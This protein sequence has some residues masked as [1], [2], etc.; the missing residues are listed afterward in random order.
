MAAYHVP[1]LGLGV[2]LAQGVW[3]I[4]ALWTQ[5]KKEQQDCGLVVGLTRQDQD[6]ITEQRIK[7]VMLSHKTAGVFVVTLGHRW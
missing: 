5:E 7:P 2:S 1:C 4:A 3:G 6:T